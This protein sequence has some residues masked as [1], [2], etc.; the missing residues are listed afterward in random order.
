VSNR[1]VVGTPDEQAVP[2]LVCNPTSG[3]HS[4]QYFNAACFQAPQAEIVAN[5]PN[6]GTYR[7]PYIHGPRY[8]RDDIGLYKA[9]KIRETKSIQIRAQAFNIGNHA[10]N[11]FLPYDSNLYLAFNA[12]GGLPTNPSTAGYTE[13]KLGHRTIQLAMKIFF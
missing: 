1:N 8:E 3:L 12:Y 10:S 7:L 11:A 2:T 6:I 5:S 9:F 13:N 4:G